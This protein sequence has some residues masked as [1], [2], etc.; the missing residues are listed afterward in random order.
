MVVVLLL[1]VVVLLLGGGAAT[2]RAKE[3]VVCGS[4]YGQPPLHLCFAYQ[5]LTTDFDQRF[6]KNMQSIGDC[7]ACFF[8]FSPDLTEEQLQCQGP[9]GSFL[10]GMILIVSKGMKW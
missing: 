1:L 3:F 5:W 7:V 8:P 10:L 4:S 2:A 9:L 6:P